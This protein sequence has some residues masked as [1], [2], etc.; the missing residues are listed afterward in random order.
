MEAVLY[1][2]IGGALMLAGIFLGVRLSRVPQGTRSK[3]ETESA[4]EQANAQG[5]EQARAQSLKEQWEHL[6]DYNGRG[7]KVGN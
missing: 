7:S 2:I 3:T 6:M 5:E 1:M 4:A